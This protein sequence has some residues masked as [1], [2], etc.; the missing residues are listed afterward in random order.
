MSLSK[1]C[2]LRGGGGCEESVEFGVRWV[3]GSE[4][5]REKNGHERLKIVLMAAE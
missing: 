1:V 4:R 5:K 2:V 3:D